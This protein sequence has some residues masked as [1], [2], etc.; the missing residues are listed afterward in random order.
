[1]GQKHKIAIVGAG[2]CGTMM[3][4]FLA[5]REHEVHVY[6]RRPDMRGRRIDLGRSINLALSERGASALNE[7]G[8][9]ERVL[10]SSVPMRERAIHSVDGKVVHQ[11]FG[12]NSKEHLYAVERHVLNN[13]LLDATKDW[14]DNIHVHF[15]QR[16]SDINLGDPKQTYLAFFDQ[17]KPETYERPF[18]YV[19]AADG[20]RSTVRKLL[21]ERRRGEFEFKCEEMPYGYKEL[22]IPAEKA[23]GMDWEFLH[24]WPRG[25]FFLLG[26][27]NCDGSISCTL[28]LPREGETSFSQLQ[29]RDGAIAVLPA[30]FPRRLRSTLR[31]S[32]RLLRAPDRCV[33]LGQGRPLAGRGQAAPAG[34][35]RARHLALL[36][37]GDEQRLRGL[38]HPQSMPDGGRRPHRRRP[39][40]PS[41]GRGRPT[42]NAI[43][44]MAMQN[45]RE[46]QHHI[47]NPHFLLR[48]RVEQELMTRYPDEYVSMHV[49]VMFTREPYAFVEACGAL[50]G[51]LLET[52]CSP[53]KSEDQIDWATVRPLI[54]NDI[55]ETY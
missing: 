46:I 34:R 18:D 40:A 45:Y 31:H 11:A 48:K 19:V 33:A 52:I 35:R 1:M 42:P 15:N 9:L 21:E 3:A 37:P 38:L 16:L 26:N 53:I 14:P 36:R 29:D 44:N 55:R 17:D 20:V 13:D 10:K 43:A 5:K 41:S 50:Q 47:A 6:E 49:L 22:L 7:L 24:L 54:D 32:G 4:L 28:F 51:S 23:G 39:S 12:R 27:P 25:Q 2:L 8:L 30:V